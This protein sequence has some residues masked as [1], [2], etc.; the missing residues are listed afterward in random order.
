M[1]YL[2]SLVTFDPL[3][4]MPGSCGRCLP[5][6]RGAYEQAAM[7]DRKETQVLYALITEDFSIGNLKNSLSSFMVI[8]LMDKNAANHWDV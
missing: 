6:S 1:G 8:W 2:S 7:G 3:G 5:S 4:T